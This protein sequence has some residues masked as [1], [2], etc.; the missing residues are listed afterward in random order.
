MINC[1]DSQHQA[2]TRKG[3]FPGFGRLVQAKLEK[4]YNL[5]IDFSGTIW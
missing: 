2:Q 1:L 5:R 3:F 4:Y